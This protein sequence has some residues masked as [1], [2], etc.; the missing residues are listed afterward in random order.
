MIASFSQLSNKELNEV[1][2]STHRILKFHTVTAMN[3]NSFLYL[4][5]QRPFAILHLYD[6][7]IVL[8]EHITKW[9]MVNLQVD[10]I[11]ISIF[12]LSLCLGF[13]QF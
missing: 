13:S 8:F 5:A 3:Y 7:H 9:M 10:S 4:L 11:F 6:D 12:I 1:K 2:N